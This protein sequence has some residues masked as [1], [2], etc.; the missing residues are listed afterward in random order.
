[1]PDLSVSGLLTEV[2]W[3]PP[4]NLSESE[5]RAI[6]ERL[7]RME[8]S[9]SW[10]IGDWWAFGEHRYGARKAAVDGCQGPSFQACVDAANVCR[11]FEIKRRRLIM[12]FSH[13]REVAALEP[14]E[15]DA[16]LDLAEAN[17]WS[18][19]ALR[20]EVHRRRVIVGVQTSDRT[21]KV[22]DLLR[23]V[24]EGAKYGCIYA[25]PPWLYDNQERQL[26]TITRG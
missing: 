12:S 20:A 17:S 23:H 7:G 6:G 11:N 14:A 21:G 3:L 26:P 9:V 24:E 19:L 22:A 18:K 5:W 8:R 13:H 2:S 15:A 1:M 25:D 4:D 10:W 16:L